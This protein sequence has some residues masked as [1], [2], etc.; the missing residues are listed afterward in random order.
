MQRNFSAEE[1]VTLSKITYLIGDAEQIMS[2]PNVPAKCPF[3]E[4]AISFLSALSKE[5]MQNK[6][7]KEYPDVITLGFWL[8]ASSLAHLEA[9]FGFRDNMLHLGRG[10]VFHIA[11]SNVPV[12]FAYSL[13]AGLLMGNANI[14]R[15]P[16]KSFP[17]VDIILRALK[18]VI[19]MYDT[20][21]PYISLIRY[22]RE[23]EINNIL[24][25]IADVRVI[26]GGNA[27]IEEL[28]KSPI[29]PRSTEITFADRFSIAV[30]DS[31]VYMQSEDKKQIASAFYNDTYLSDQNACTSPRLVVWFGGRKEQAKSE[32]WDN[33]HKLV[34]E[35]YNFQSIM[36]V[37]KLTSACIMASHEKGTE[38]I[39]TGDNL[40]V[41]VC[42]PR[43]TKN[44]I[45]LRDNSGYFFEYDC[46]DLMELR[47]LCNDNR[48][49]TIGV[50]GS[51]DMLKQLL[52]S[53]VR[54]IDRIVAIGQTMDFDFLWD[55]YNLAER[56]TRTIVL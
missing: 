1:K 10:T 21:C 34:I 53:G 25:S 40:L 28:R 3:N 31:D 22:E 2:M 52:L 47:E 48:I 46:D 13:V 36:A 54:G 44:V 7:A 41:R 15:V 5:L 17:Q 43:I 14:V 23:R 9:R 35:K 20:M 32:F 45:E 24:S 16:S 11:P 33:L 37:N 8:R 42:I 18:N 39:P 55:G 30:I 26:W 49:Q 29:P 38:I 56:L 51:S 4:E 12:N 50:I 19:S 27:T 6:E